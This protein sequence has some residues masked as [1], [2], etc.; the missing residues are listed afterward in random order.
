METVLPDYALA[1]WGA[2]LSLSSIRMTNGPISPAA[3]RASIHPTISVPWA[4]RFLTSSG[5]TTTM[6]LLHSMT[7]GIKEEFEYL[8]RIE[9]GVQSPGE[10]LRLRSGSCRDF[11][12]LMMEAV[13]SLGLAARFVS[14]YIFAPE[15]Q[16]RTPSAGDR[17]TAGCRR[18]CRAPDGSTSIRPTASSGIAT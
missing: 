8:R 17:R 5:S 14:G 4:A 15:R 12:V 6:T 9:K 18:T 2:H 13:R 16:P 3:W 7:R 10:T 11:A 1:D